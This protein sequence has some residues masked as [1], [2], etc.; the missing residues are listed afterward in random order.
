M[1]QILL[2]LNPPSGKEI[3]L[4]LA[5][6]TIGRS[7]SCKLHL[8]YPWISRQHAQL[9]RI[10]DLEDLTK[11]IYRL[12]DNDSKNG[13]FIK[14]AGG[15]NYR[16]LINEEE[17]KDFHDLVHGDYLSFGRPPNAVELQYLA[18]PKR[19]STDPNATQS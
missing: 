14:T 15:T 17:M 4:T 19:L 1:Q 18:F 11:A 10:E 3:K 9:V 6:I 5:Q 16:R 12:I 2:I 13:T 8:P 7:Q